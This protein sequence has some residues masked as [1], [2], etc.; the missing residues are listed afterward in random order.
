MVWLDETTQKQVMKVKFGI[1]SEVI[2]TKPDVQVQGEPYIPGHYVAKGTVMDYTDTGLAIVKFSNVGFLYKIKLEELYEAT[3]WRANDIFY[4]PAVIG[5]AKGRTGA[6]LSVPKGRDRIGDLHFGDSTMFV[7]E[8]RFDGELE[9]L[10]AGDNVIF[11]EFRNG[12]LQIGTISSIVATFT[13]VDS[14]SAL[15]TTRQSYYRSE[16][17]TGSRSIE[18]YPAQG[19]DLEGEC[20]C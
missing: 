11:Q 9:K 14:F 18:Q 15:E 4:Q 2:W 10:E 8:A 16:S 5:M 12:E 20:R 17:W 6:V 19:R 3:M 7:S 1:G 13:K